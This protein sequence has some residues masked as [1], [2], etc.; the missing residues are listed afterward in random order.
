MSTLNSP[1]GQSA[2]TTTAE[3]SNRDPPGLSNEILDVVGVTS[4]EFECYERNYTSY[5]LTTDH[6]L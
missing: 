6:Q 3:D 5:V 4:A 2:N 1:T